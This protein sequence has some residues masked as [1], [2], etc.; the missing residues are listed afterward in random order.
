LRGDGGCGAAD[1]GGA[2]GVVGEADSDRVIP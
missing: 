2:T 1:Q